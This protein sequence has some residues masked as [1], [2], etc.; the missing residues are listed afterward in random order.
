M[1]AYEKKRGKKTVGQKE[2]PKEENK[3]VKAKDTRT[4]LAK[5]RA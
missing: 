4:K 2:K 3:E 5:E 1:I